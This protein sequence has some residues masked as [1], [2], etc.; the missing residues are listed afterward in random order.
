MT[1]NKHQRPKLIASFSGTFRKFALGSIGNLACARRFCIV[2]QPLLAVLFGVDLLRGSRQPK[3]MRL[4]LERRRQMLRK[5]LPIMPARVQMKLMRYPMRR[6]Q[7]IELHAPLV[8]PKIILAPAIKINLQTH[9]TRPI[10][11]HRER[12][13]ALPERHIHLRT[14]RLPQL[15]RHRLS[16]VA[17]H[18]DLRR[19]INQ[20][21]AVR[22]N[23]HKQIRI[24]Q[25]KPQRAI[26]LPSKR[27]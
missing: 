4:K 27:R 12:A 2:A 13:F 25:R 22:A 8:K 14:E 1:E 9:R 6:Q 16:L 5:I 15:R 11:H 19:H 7:L 18:I 17:G 24:S 26:S 23:R 20:S 21:R 3:R 10:S